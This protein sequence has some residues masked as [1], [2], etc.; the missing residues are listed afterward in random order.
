MCTQRGRA[1]RPKDRPAQACRRSGRVD[2][3]GSLP[4]LSVPGTRRGCQPGKATESR[5]PRGSND[6]ED[7]GH[8][9]WSSP[10]E[11]TYLPFTLLPCVTGWESPVAMVIQSNTMTDH[12]SSTSEVPTAPAAPRWS[13][14]GWLIRP[15]RYIPPHRVPPVATDRAVGRM[16]LVGEKG[17]RSARKEGHA[18]V[19][20]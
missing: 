13:Y 6:Q 8:C 9:W 14:F 4:R 17:Q 19:Y 12:S 16:L 5:S 7:R 11:E 10:V 2:R 3:A 1:K 15:D 20:T 18:E